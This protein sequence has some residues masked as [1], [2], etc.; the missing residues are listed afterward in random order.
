MRIIPGSA[1]MILRDTGPAHDSIKRD[2]REEVWR[3][4]EVRIFELVERRAT[5]FISEEMN[6]GS[7]YGTSVFCVLIGLNADLL[8][9]LIGFRRQRRGDSNRSTL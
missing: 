1:D 8:L 6:R 9:F 5:N 2:N 4:Y 7:G 3:G